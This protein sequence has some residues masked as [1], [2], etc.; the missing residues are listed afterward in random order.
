VPGIKNLTEAFPGK[1]E[2]PVD[3]AVDV[4][5]KRKEI[6]ETDLPT[7]YPICDI[8]EKTVEKYIDLVCCAKSLVISGPM[9]V[10]ENKELLK[11][12]RNCLKQA[13][14]QGIFASCGGH[15]IA[16]VEKLGLE[17]R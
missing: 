1:I 2:V 12:Q 9:G 7:N 5:G 17:K 14:R 3:L 10:F 6:S 16:A 4:N 15:T 8:G 11:V 13:H